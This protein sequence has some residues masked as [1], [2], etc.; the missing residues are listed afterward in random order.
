M[1]IIEWKQLATHQRRVGPNTVGYY[2]T[3]KESYLNSH[4][5][6]LPVITPLLILPG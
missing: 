6:K 4:K 2:S 1:T 3:Q 5:S